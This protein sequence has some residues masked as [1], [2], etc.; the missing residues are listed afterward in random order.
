MTLTGHGGNLLAS[1]VPPRFR[2][3]RPTR[4]LFLFSGRASGGHKSAFAISHRGSGVSGLPGV[5]RVDSCQVHSLLYHVRSSTYSS[6]EIDQLEEFFEAHLQLHKV[7]Y[8]YKKARESYALPDLVGDFFFEEMVNRCSFDLRVYEVDSDV[9]DRG[10]SA[11]I[12]GARDW[13]CFFDEKPIWRVQPGKGNCW[14]EFQILNDAGSSVPGLKIE[15]EA[16]GGQTLCKES[17]EDGRVYFSGFSGCHCS[18]SIIISDG[19]TYHTV[20]DGDCLLSL[21]DQYNLPARAILRAEQNKELFEKRIDP[22]ILH[23]GD[24][25]YIPREVREGGPLATNRCHTY[26]LYRF[27]CLFRL[28]LD[29]SEVVDEDHS[30]MIRYR[31]TLDTGKVYNARVWPTANNS[32]QVIKIPILAG[33]GQLDVFLDE[34]DPEATLSFELG[35]GHLCPVDETR[36]LQ[37]RLENL[38][39]HVG[40]VDGDH[41][42]KTQAGVEEFMLGCEL[43]ENDEE[44]L[45]AALEKEHGS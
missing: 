6:F 27:H 37:E 25:V 12:P 11:M 8:G 33:R 22:K 24:V 26:Q 18:C 9:L 3:D 38:G 20:A 21:A 32:P 36:G 31:I 4:L 1:D 29:L 45:H 39:Y 44:A 43:G 7:Y 17:D 16:S 40:K 2:F 14:V 35:L 34:D 41:G 15:I 42:P 19:L 10:S 5:R 23:P 13:Y 30:G 28:K